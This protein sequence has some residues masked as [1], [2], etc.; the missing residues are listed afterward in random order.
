LSVVE[1]EVGEGQAEVE[2]GGGLVEVAWLLWVE[3]GW[4]GVGGWER[5]RGRVRGRGGGER[6]FKR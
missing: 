6:Y 4:G 5:G 3:W 1:R 2:G